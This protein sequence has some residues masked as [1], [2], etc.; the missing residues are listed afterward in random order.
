MGAVQTANTRVY[1]AQ[2]LTVEAGSRLDQAFEPANA[3]RA[4]FESA[5][6]QTAMVEE[7]LAELEAEDEPKITEGLQT[8][9]AN[10]G[11]ALSDGQDADNIADDLVAVLED[12]EPTETPTETAALLAARQHTVVL[13]GLG[14]ILIILPWVLLWLWA[15]NR[16]PPQWTR[17][18]GQELTWLGLVPVKKRAQAAV[19]NL[20]TEL[21]K[22]SD[23]N[24]AAKARPVNEK[25]TEIGEIA[26]TRETVME[27]SREAVMQA[28]ASMAGDFESQPLDDALRGIVVETTGTK[29]E[30]RAAANEAVEEFLCAKA[31]KIVNQEF[32]AE[33]K[34]IV[35]AYL[36]DQLDPGRFLASLIPITLVVAGTFLE[37]FWPGS[38]GGFVND[39]IGE[40][41]I[42]SGLLLNVAQHLEHL[43]TLMPVPFLA[44]LT[45]YVVMGLKL[46][47][48]LRRYDVTAE[49]YMELLWRLVAAFVL[50][51][52]GAVLARPVAEGQVFWIRDWELAPVWFGILFGV[53]AGAMPKESFHTLL[54]FI[55]ARFKQVFDTS[56]DRSRAPHILDKLEPRHPLRILDG[57]DYWDEQRIEEA[58][59]A[60]C[61]ALVYDGI[62]KLLYGTAFPASQIV[63]WV[64]QAALFL[65][66]GA[67]EGALFVTTF[68]KLGLNSATKLLDFTAD[69]CGKQTLLVAAESVQGSTAA[70]NPL[71]AAQLAALCAK[72][73]VGQAK[74][75]ADAAV[76]AI[77]NK[78]KDDTLDDDSEKKIRAAVEAVATAKKKGDEAHTKVSSG[79]ETLK[80]AADA[81]NDLQS[82]LK[83]V[84]EDNAQ[85]VQEELETAGQ[86]KKFTEDLLKSVR[87]Q[88]GKAFDTTK[89]VDKAE[90]LVEKLDRIARPLEETQ[91]KVETFREACKTVLDEVQKADNYKDTAEVPTTVTEAEAEDKR[92]KLHAEAKDNAT[93]V[94]E[95]DSA[96]QEAQERVKEVVDLLEDDQDADKPAKLI[97]ALTTTEQWAKDKQAETTEKAKKLFEHADGILETVKAAAKAVEDARSADKP[98]AT[99]PLT[100]EVL[101]TIRAC[102]GSYNSLERVRRYRTKEKEAI[103]GSTAS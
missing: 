11:S 41:E 47:L 20:N 50:G 48:R 61:H 74:E 78:N 98:A 10:M 8:A 32:T 87:E 91:E 92:K 93:P 55:W 80:H 12:L 23:A 75:D 68:R 43:T 102:L 9:L 38:I 63:D 45:A 65:T 28:I 101:E 18:W 51:L 5:V 44:V 22:L 52:V 76:E 53:L 46:I 13:W 39:L 86:N 100:L 33:A 4:M 97:E 27:Y 49:G 40:A 35:E 88:L 73:Q 62:K 96:L 7:E 58:G 90:A 24:R 14:Y 64:D 83:I 54:H 81:A 21:R 99:S 25:E 2:I 16:R 95:A 67:E 84:H 6:E 60:D 26:A 42:G 37:V 59:V 66:A 3:L 82:A 19:Q 71:P 15:S 103:K 69:E 1:E 77:K 56:G 29:P 72:I 34:R 17:D 30:A 70:E 79:G 89:A 85:K 31:T 36:A 94:L 57:I